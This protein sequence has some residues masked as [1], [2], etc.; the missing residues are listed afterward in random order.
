MAV[1]GNMGDSNN[2]GPKNGG[3][4]S[5]KV[6]SGNATTNKQMPASNGISQKG[7]SLNPK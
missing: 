7:G 1:N 4:S 6:P 5:P 2:I 3:S